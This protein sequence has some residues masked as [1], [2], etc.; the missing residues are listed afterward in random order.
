MISRLTAFAGNPYSLGSRATKRDISGI[1]CERKGLIVVAP[2]DVD[3][4]PRADTPAFEEFQQV[5]VPL[6]DST[7]HI[8][9]ARF[10]LG[11]EHQPSA[12]ATAGTLKFA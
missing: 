4:R 12:T 11:Q 7:H 1:S 5:P 8:V 10:G 6:V 9:L 3:T 2:R